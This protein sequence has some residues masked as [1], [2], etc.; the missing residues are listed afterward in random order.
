MNPQ[1]RRLILDL[2]PLL[3][4]VPVL[5][6]R[7]FLPATAVFMVLI[8][9]SLALGYFF[10]RKL[11]PMPLFTAAVVLVFGGLTLYFKDP[12]FFKLKVTFIYCTF[13]A[14]LLFGLAFK[15][16]FIKYVFSE[17]FDLDEAGW[18]KLTLRM[19]IF[20]FALAALNEIIWRSFSDK[21]WALSKIGFV[22]LTF[23]FIMAQVPL[24]LRHGLDE[25]KKG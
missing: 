22:V 17:A 2:G 25:T 15:R 18:K 12:R 6:F 8:V 3:I 13:G 16:L 1:L 7:G 24:I 19:G 11:S 14:L 4:F 23:L 5:I 10:E 21:V 9:A 20:F